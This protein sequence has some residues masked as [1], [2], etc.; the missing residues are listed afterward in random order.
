MSII[1][2][3]QI[4][5]LNGL[6]DRQISVARPIKNCHSTYLDELNAPEGTRYVVLRKLLAVGRNSVLIPQR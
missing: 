3:A 5:F 6:L 2:K 1:G 4:G